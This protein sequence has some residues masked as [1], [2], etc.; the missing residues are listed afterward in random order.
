MRN[1]LSRYYAANPIWHLGV[2]ILGLVVVAVAG[3]IAR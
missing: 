3:I 2:A 1:F